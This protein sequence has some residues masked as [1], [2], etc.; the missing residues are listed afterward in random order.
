MDSGEIAQMLI[1]DLSQRADSTSRKRPGK[2]KRR[3]VKLLEELSTRLTA[4]GVG[5]AHR[6][7]ISRD[8][9]SALPALSGDIE[10]VLEEHE[11]LAKRFTALQIRRTGATGG[12]GGRIHL[13]HPSDSAGD[14]NARSVGSGGGEV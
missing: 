12:G 6:L 11:D 9:T 10:R 5:A 7:A 8:D 3:E 2:S 14:R 13:S 1:D 4:E